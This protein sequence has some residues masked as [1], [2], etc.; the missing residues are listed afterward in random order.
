MNLYKKQGGTPSPTSLA[1]FDQIAEARIE[2]DKFLEDIKARTSE[3]IDKDIRSDIG[4]G[5]ARD[6]PGKGVGRSGL[7]PEEARLEEKNLKD[8]IWKKP[9]MNDIVTALR[10]D[11][12]LFLQAL[13][14]Q[15]DLTV[16][17]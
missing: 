1:L 11:F 8:N 10:D 6:R 5:I 17:N 16:P 13:W 4:K 3:Q 2:A 14:E 7:Y 9:F 15:L 12:K